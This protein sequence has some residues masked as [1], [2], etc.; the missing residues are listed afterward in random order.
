M[1]EEVFQW[2]I[3]S[4]KSPVI[5]SRFDAWVVGRNKLLYRLIEVGHVEKKHRSKA[6]EQQVRQVS[7]FNNTG[8][9]I[10]PYANSGAFSV[11]IWDEDV[12]LTL[13]TELV[14]VLAIS[15]EVLS[16]LPVYPEPCLKLK[17]DHA[18]C[19]TACAYG[20]DQQK[21]V[22]ERLVDSRWLAPE[23]SDADAAETKLVYEPSPWIGEARMWS[24]R[25]NERSLLPALAGAL[26]VFLLFPLGRWLG[27]EVKLA[28]VKDEIRQEHLRLAQ[29]IEKRDQAV[30]LQASNHA[31]KGIVDG[32]SQFKAMVIFDEAATS[33]ALSIL[34]WR[35]QQRKL[36]VNILDEELDNR[37]YVEQ[38]SAA[39]VFRD[40]R[41]DP[42]IGPGE[43]VISISIGESP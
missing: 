28:F 4:G 21:W 27:W 32:F 20:Y 2:E 3:E 17:Q 18:D 10:Y 12:R 31:L 41:V 26:L 8:S 42:G 13:L 38:L 15:S 36:T 24:D 11:W 40:V 37:S 30:E 43:A 19:V 39:D 34:E 23:T 35:Y 5:G 29:V 22:S 33:S 14:E 16:S 1:Q 7:P 25:L 9:Y 6:L